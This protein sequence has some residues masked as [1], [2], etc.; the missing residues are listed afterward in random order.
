VQQ[1]EH[2][3]WERRWAALQAAAA[4]A[5]EPCVGLAHVPWIPAGAKGGVAWLVRSRTPVLFGVM[6]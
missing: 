5:R 4:A 6:T 3:E 1:R 2:A